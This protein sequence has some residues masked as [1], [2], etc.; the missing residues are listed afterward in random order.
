[1]MNDLDRA[2][3]ALRLYSAVDN[4]SKEQPLAEILDLVKQGVDVQATDK[5]NKTLL[6]WA[7]EYG[8]LNVCE[9]LIQQNAKIDAVNDSRNTPLQNAAQYGQTKIVKLLLEHGADIH[10]QNKE[11]NT[12]L[13]LADGLNKP[14]ATKFLLT[15]GANIW[16]KSSADAMPLDVDKTGLLE[17][18]RERW[19]KVLAQ[20]KDGNLDSI[21]STQ[22]LYHLASV[23]QPHNPKDIPHPKEFIRILFQQ[24]LP[25][26]EKFNA[27]YEEIFGQQRIT[28]TQD[29]KTAREAAKGSRGVVL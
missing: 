1:M 26:N 5:D 16:A 24:Y 25:H 7:A 27:M 23:M 13:R 28:V 10:A 14:E 21:N 3:E 19:E 12:P 29:L 2:N 8:H 4:S 20:V 17:P 15:Q 9:E 18:H 11:G 6:H 22:D